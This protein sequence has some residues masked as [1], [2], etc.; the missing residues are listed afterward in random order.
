MLGELWNSFRR[1]P[2]WVQ[3]W[4]VLILMPANFVPLAFLG[5][6]MGIWVAVLSVGGMALNMPILVLERGFTRALALPHL[7]LWTP[8]VGL[9]LWLILSGTA[10]GPY[11]VMLSA[12]L[13]IDL[14]S[15]GFDARDGWHIWR[16][17][18]ARSAA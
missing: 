5:S 18:R 16:D 3:L 9:M 13:V 6:P 1:L 2:V 7:L 17:A 12:L 14:I 11:A 8:L 15:L 10:T 4:M